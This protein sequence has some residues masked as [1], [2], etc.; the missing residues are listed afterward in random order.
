MAR[1]RIGDWLKLRRHPWKRPAIEGFRAWR[2]AGGEQLR[3]VFTDLGP[4]DVVL[5]FGG[6]LG[7]W[8]AQ[9]LAAC[10]GAQVHVFEPH[11][12][13]ARMLTARYARKDGVQV[14]PFALGSESGMFALSD[15]GDASS[16]L[17]TEAGG[18][19]GRIERADS[20]LAAEPFAE[21]AL[22]KINIE[23]GEYDLLPA[24]ADAGL[25][26]RFR[27]LQIQFHLLKPEHV[28][29]RQAIRK[30]L[31]RSHRCRWSFDFVWEE[32]VRR[33]DDAA[34]GGPT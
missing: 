21:I 3:R 20:F 24:L 28:A 11:P 26:T 23:G 4:G 25:L 13:F 15:A 30:Q 19:T 31:A 18:V 1:H 27:R 9:V 34:T 8:T 17:A 32:W 7:E 22:A 12:R 6:Y 2:R 5:D 33:D 14:H 10:P 29:A 16:A